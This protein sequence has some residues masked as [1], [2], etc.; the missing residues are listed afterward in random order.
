VCAGVLPGSG[1]TSR[2]SGLQAVEAAGCQTVGTG[3]LHTSRRQQTAWTTT[4]TPAG[5]QITVDGDTST[6]D[7]VLGLASGAA[8]NPTI[9]DPRSEDAAQLE[10]AVTALLQV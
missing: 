5:V 6:N 2:W 3:C 7:T 9:T 8:G 1:C 4:C 10:A